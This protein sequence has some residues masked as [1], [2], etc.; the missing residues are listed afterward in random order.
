MKKIFW[1]NFEN[2]H[3]IIC[4]LGIKIKIRKKILSRKEDSHDVGIISF[5]IN[6]SIYNYGA[7]LHSYAFQKYLNKFGV[8]SVILDYARCR[9]GKGY[10]ANKIRK[11][12]LEKD[13]SSLY[14]NLIKLG[15]VFIKKVK[16]DKFFR[17]NCIITKYKYYPATIS[18]LKTINRFVCETDVTWSKFKHG[19]D[20]AFMCDYNNMK[21]KPNVAY[22]IDFGSKLLSE[23]DKKR[24]LKYSKNFKYISIRNIFKLNYFKE[25][26]QRDDVVIT[27]DPVF[28]L[29]VEDYLPIV[30]TPKINDEYLLVYNCK[31]NHTEMLKQA[32]Y[33]ATKNNLKLIIINCYDKNIIEL[34][35]SIPTPYGIEEFLGLIKN[36]KYFFTNSYHG[37]C[38][39]IIFGIPFAAFSRVGNNE[40]ILTVLELFG[41]NE[42]FVKSTDIPS[43]EIDYEKVREKWLLLRK[44]AEKFLRIANVI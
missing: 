24:L 4:I 14:Y 1:I 37:I 27:I 6:T 41:L 25:I 7:A 11:C 12:W 39:A 10:C 17:H 28:L 26:V 18:E 29:D 34:K 44:E 16:F 32:K 9:L 19:Y 15:H 30:K 2:K 31:E 13:Y 38:F 5:N 22:S 23:N 36:C 8:D 43:E 20:R 3:I 35:D 21:T 40:K 33:Y 42:R